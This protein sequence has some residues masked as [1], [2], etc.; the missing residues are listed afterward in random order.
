MPQVAW[1]A[2]ILVA[3][4][5]AR[6]GWPDE[7][8]PDQGAAGLYQALLQLKTTAKVMHVV[9]HPDDEDGAMLT[10]C[11]R[12]LGAETM[13]F[14]VTRGEGGANLISKHAFD[15]LGILRTLEHAE[16]AKY[17]GVE[18]RYSSAAD[19]GYSKTLDEAMKHWGR[20]DR[21][22]KELVAEIRRFKPDV[23]V[24][25]F[26]GDARDGHGHHQFA[27]VLAQQA[28]LASGDAQRFPE[29]NLDPWQPK[30]LYTNNIR[31]EWRP[32]G[33]DAWTVAVPTGEFNPVLGR[34]YA[35]V[36]RYGLGFQRSQGFTGHDGPAGESVS[37]YRLVKS[38]LPNYA[39]ATE[40]TFLDGID[41]S[42]VGLR[43][44][45][46]DEPPEWI[47]AKLEEIQS[48]VDRAWATYDPRDL[49]A[50][51]PALIEGA[52]AADALVEEMDRAKISN[53]IGLTLA[54]RIL[55][56]RFH[57][58]LRRALGIDFQV[59]AAA[60][61]VSGGPDPPAFDLQNIVPGQQVRVTL[62]VVHRGD[63]P[64]DIVSGSLH[65]AADEEFGARK[66]RFDATPLEYNKPWTTTVDVR[67]P[68][69][70]PTTRPTWRRETI[71]KAFYEEDAFAAKP[72]QPDRPWGSVFLVVNGQKLGFGCPLLTRYQHPEYGELTQPLEIV[73][74]V[75]IAFESA[76]AVIVKG[77]REHVVNVNVRNGS[78]ELS[79]GQV[80]LILP[81][82][83]R[84]EPA[85]QA[86]SLARA[87]A[88]QSLSFTVHTPES[89]D[90]APATI[91]AV[92]TCQ[93]REYTEDYE[94]ITARDLGRA[95]YYRP[96]QQLLRS[97]DARI[98]SDLQVGYVM[99]AGDEIPAALGQLGVG[100]T[101]LDAAEL[102][103][104]DLSRFDTI[105]IG[106]RAYAVRADLIAANARL[107]EYVHDGG[108]L[109]VHYQTPEFDHNFGPYPYRM[110][111]NPEEVSEEDAQVTILHPD[112]P[113]FNTPNLITATDFDGWFEQR[114]SKFWQSW[115]ERYEPLLE[116]HD[117]GQPRQTGGLL[118][119]GYGKGTYIYSAYAL[120]R[121]LPQG[122][123][124]AYR[125][126]ANLTAAGVSDRE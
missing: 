25:R 62:R 111:R 34:S 19:Y 16:S 85:E 40:Q 116:C 81:E 121:Q 20:D 74:R 103:D 7:I 18:V 51:A 90:E 75:S 30:K 99:G 8:P 58:A 36:A 115:D 60:A 21:V 114:G 119:A 55:D 101:L 39:P 80:K 124:G 84:A 43:Q 48:C 66:L 38:A 46:G 110:G 44:Y 22:L 2:G 126:L 71:G 52:K 79:E 93:G 117:Q 76:N 109:V 4:A 33:K 82:G 96:A 92:A 45:A 53:Q 104:G 88:T 106:V 32:E 26:R 94:T 122:I 42:I 28:F 56:M 105:M 61:N 95:N 97:I 47:V 6:G 72:N 123:P 29:L 13:L 70:M 12:G 78:P 112:H 17:Y 37:Y 113:L 35:Q 77:R 15:E 50:V 125:L 89:L 9:A 24:S 100:V 63:L 108:T 86:F 59:V 98:P 68:D 65:P 41:T 83:W 120:Y 31:P 23:I 54:D 5:G 10:Y 118:V 3:A 57:A 49:D 1:L 64:M 11:A 14:S 107:L 69:D 73:P 87:E 27:G 67:V 91:K 102:A